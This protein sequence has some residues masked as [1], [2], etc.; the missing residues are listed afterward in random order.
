MFDHV[1][2]IVV[3]SACHFAA[4]YLLAIQTPY[5]EQL[6]V[7][8][9]A[10]V[11]I[12]LAVLLI[13]I[14][15][16]SLLVVAGLV[17]YFSSRMTPS[18]K[19]SFYFGIL[20]SFTLTHGFLFSVGVPIGYINYVRV[21]NLAFL[22]PLL[23]K[24]GK[25][26]Q[27]LNIIDMLALAFFSWQFILTL[28]GSKFTIAMRINIWIVVDYVIPYFAIRFFLKDYYLT[29]IAIFFALLSQAFIAIAEGLMT[30]KI[31]V[32]LE[33]LSGFFPRGIPAYYF[34]H[35]FLRVE[36]SY[37]NPLIA[38]LFGNF[39]FLCAY[40][41]YKFEGF[42]LT[43]TYQ[44][45]ISLCF[46]VAAI[47]G[48]FFT[49]SRAGMGGLILI[50]GVYHGVVWA[51][52]RKKDPMFKLMICLAI[53]VVIALQF[54]QE[55][56]KEEF[57]YRYMLVD[58]SSEVIMSNWFAGDLHV[59]R[60]PRMQVLIQGEGIIDLVNSYVY[61]ALFYGLTGLAILLM[62]IYFGASKTYRTLKT[63]EGGRY[64]LGI[65]CFCCYI[66]LIFNIAS[67]SP[68]GLIY[69]WIWFLLAICSNIVFSYEI[70]NRKTTP[71]IG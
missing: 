67:T 7:Y 42:K 54:G 71:L 39:A 16:I 38:S 55:F 29:Y 34:R 49:G 69:F 20:F 3:I 6:K 25:R 13:K 47:G 53:M 48:T 8:F 17:N 12:V 33:Q 45:R 14:P 32:Y 30:W 41:F 4:Y 36:A 68:I 22:L 50:L 63:G 60:D 66:I 21:L 51:L 59:L 11:S 70:E 9:T 57:G 37:G 15:F 44:K 52:K 24:G 58:V 1:K 2:L 26:G 62:A 23:L 56:M 61:I 35:G 27:R 64:A 46:L 65:F 31:Y 18:E 19:I 5:K 10:S 40:I 28:I 43:D